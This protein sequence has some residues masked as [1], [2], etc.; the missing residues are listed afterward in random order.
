MDMDTG[1]FIMVAERSPEWLA[2]QALVEALVDIVTEEEPA[3]AEIRDQLLVGAERAAGD[4][5][6]VDYFADLATSVDRILEAIAATL[7]PPDSSV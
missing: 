2:A 6:M 4:E 5:P 1:E 3:L 7:A